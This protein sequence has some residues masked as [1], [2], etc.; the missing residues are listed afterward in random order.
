MSGLVDILIGDIESQRRINFTRRA[1]RLVEIVEK[2]TL[3]GGIKVFIVE[4]S[5]YIMG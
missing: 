2:I 5:R 4:G 3:T 1:S